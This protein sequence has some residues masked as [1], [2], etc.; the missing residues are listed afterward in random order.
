MLLFIP[1][2]LCA[3][4]RRPPKCALLTAEAITSS[5]PPATRG[6]HAASPPRTFGNELVWSCSTRRGSGVR[7]CGAGSD[8]AEPLR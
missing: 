5:A 1:R 3:L 7:W 2:S 6:D 8:E 4:K